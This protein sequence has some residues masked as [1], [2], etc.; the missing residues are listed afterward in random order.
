MAIVTCLVGLHYGHIIVH[1]KSHRDRILHWSISSSS[2]IILGL[3]LDLLGMHINKPLYTFSYMCITA[4]SAGILFA[5]IYFMP[6]IS[7]QLSSMDSIGGSLRT[8]LAALLGYMRC[9][10]Q[11]QSISILDC[12]PKLFDQFWFVHFEIREKVELALIETPAGSVYRALYMYRLELLYRRWCR[13][14]LS[15]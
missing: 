14:K 5:A 8:T 2:L 1:F 12:G 7:C 3:T 15:L 13:T 9:T 6:A 4:G 11:V 10:A